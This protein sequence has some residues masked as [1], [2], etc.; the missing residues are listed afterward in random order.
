MAKKI[1]IAERVILVSVCILF[2]F[3]SFCI[4]VSVKGRLSFAEI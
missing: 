1:P 3:D 2:I 4:R